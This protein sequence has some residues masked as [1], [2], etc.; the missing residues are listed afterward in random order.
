M[1]TPQKRV[2]NGKASW[3]VTKAPRLLQSGILVT[4]AV[5]AVRVRLGAIRGRGI[6]DICAN[7]RRFVC[8]CVY[9]N[10]SLRNDAR[11]VTSALRRPVDP[12]SHN[13]SPC[14][15]RISVRVLW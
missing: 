10:L 6:K 9:Q 3:R 13:L 4:R 11:K 2:A 5:R 15:H 8:V 1:R 14:R 12:K 7:H